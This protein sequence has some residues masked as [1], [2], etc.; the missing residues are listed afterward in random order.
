MRILIAIGYKIYNFI[1]VAFETEIY[2]GDDDD[3][4]TV[5]LN[6]LHEL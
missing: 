2:Y 1:V 5:Q 3:D 6:Y 4:D